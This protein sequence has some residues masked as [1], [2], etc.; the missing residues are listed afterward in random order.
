VA[1]LLRKHGIVHIRPLLGG[2]NAWR[3]LGYPLENS[4]PA[5]TAGAAARE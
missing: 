5:E 4:E 3:N 1:L 2:L